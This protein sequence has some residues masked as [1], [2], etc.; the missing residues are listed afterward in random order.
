MGENVIAIWRKKYKSWLDDPLHPS[1]VQDWSPKE[2][3][4]SCEGIG[5][6]RSLEFILNFGMK[7][8]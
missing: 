8:F 3:I 5:G 1:S 7:E 4:K 6:E 2:L